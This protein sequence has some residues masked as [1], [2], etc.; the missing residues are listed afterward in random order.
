MKSKLLI[1]DDD[2][3]ICYLLKT[4][5]Q[6]GGFD[7]AE[8]NTGKAGLEL[9]QGKKN[10]GFSP[11]LVLLDVHLPDM[12]GIEVLDGIKRSFPDLPVILMTGFG[13]VEQAVEAMRKGAYDYILK[14]LNMDE[15]Q[16]RVQKAL[17]LSKLKDQVHFLSEQVNAA[18]AQDYIV[19]SSPK[20]KKVY[21]TISIIAQSQSTTVL[22]RGESGTGK[23][24]VAR[25]IHVLSER[26]NKPFVEINATALPEELLESEL[27]GHE[28]GAFSGATKTK[29]GLFEVADGGSLFLDEIGDMNLHLQAKILR[30]LQEKKIRRVGA[31][32]HIEVDIRLITATN[33]N[34]EEAVKMG[35]FR[36]DLY[37]RLNVVPI[38][39]PPLRE[40]KEDIEEF[41][42]FFISKFNVEFRKN[43]QT[44]DKEALE[45]LCNYSW[46]GNIREL[47][48]IMERTMLL[49]C[50]GNALQ[51]QHLQSM[52]LFSKEKSVKAESCTSS[53]DNSLPQK[54]HS[55]TEIGG[56]VTLEKIERDHIEGVLKYAQGNKNQAAQILGI[57]RTTLYNKLRKYQL[58]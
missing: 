43:V 52:S 16:L 53:L 13:S 5:F 56:S 57:D 10:K 41:V 48:N 19:G 51:L 49:E 17:D 38:E 37:Y 30:A 25:Q 55:H 26:K 34:L 29:K 4:I 36:E 32:D 50:K 45:A 27:F 18:N 8:A 22:I 2:E 31:V 58:S 46:P 11:H 24:V 39:L 3:N 7:I 47:K 21:E 23:E 54:E 12:S 42:K 15:I 6:S 28:A 14:P 20:M 33:K 35:L 40:R 1:V 44:I 9:L